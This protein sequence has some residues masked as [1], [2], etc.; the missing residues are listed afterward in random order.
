LD[1]AR[2]RIAAVVA[3]AVRTSLTDA[4]NAVAGVFGLLPGHELVTGTIDGIG[5]AVSVVFNALGLTGIPEW[6]AISGRCCSA[7]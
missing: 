4:G 2:L 7:R 3:A 1:R 6:L 5:N